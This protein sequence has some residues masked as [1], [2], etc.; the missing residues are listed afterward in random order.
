[1]KKVV[2]RSDTRGRSVYDWLDSHHSFS[3]DEYY[4]PERVHFGALR[5]LNDDRVAP[6]EGFQTH[7]HKNMEIVSIPL[8]G[9]LAHGDSKKNSRTITVGDIQVMS[10][11]TGIYHSEMNGSKSEPVEF[12]QIWII[13]KERNTHPLYQDYDIRGLLK[14]DESTPPKLLQDTWFSMGEIGAGKTVEYTL[15][16]T[17]MGVYVFLIEGEVKIDDVILTRRDGLGISEI[18]NFEIETLKDSKILLIEVPM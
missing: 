5:V 8:K 14:K 10:A 13:P 16:G 17:D 4:N 1:M 15:H 6:G 9:L 11:G 7:P 12:L 2:H 3:F 18:K